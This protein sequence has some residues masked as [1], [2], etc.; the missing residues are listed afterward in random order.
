MSSLRTCT[1]ERHFIEQQEKHPEATGELTRL[2]HQLAD[3]FAHTRIVRDDDDAVRVTGNKSVP[4]AFG[5]GVVE[6]VLVACLQ[7]EV[8]QAVFR[9]LA[10]ALRGGDQRQRGLQAGILHRR[11]GQRGLPPAPAGQPTR[12]VAIGLVG[13]YRLGMAEQNQ[14]SHASQNARHRTERNGRF[15]IP[16]LARYPERMRFAD[17]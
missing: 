14:C 17:V 8:L 12:F 6:C 7:R 3:Q 2:M 4:D 9:R 16:A 10:R 1:I 11:A 5:R 13:P 15:A